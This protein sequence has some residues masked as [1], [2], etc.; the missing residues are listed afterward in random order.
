MASTQRALDELAEPDWIAETASETGIGGRVLTAYAGASLRVAD[1]QPECGIGWNT[2]AGIGQVESVHGAYDGA[3]L[4]ADGQ[5]SPQITG[6]ALDGD[7]GVMEIPDTDGGELD[8][9]TDP[10]HFD[11]A[12]LT[13]AM[14]PLC[15]RR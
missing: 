9:E 11:D 12:V 15:R 3:S 10:H 13:A 8:G 4:A 2:L 6:I 7:P 5:V 1:E 14:Y